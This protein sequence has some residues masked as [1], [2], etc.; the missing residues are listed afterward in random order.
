MSATPRELRTAMGPSTVAL[1]PAAPRLDPAEIEAFHA[2]NPVAGGSRRVP[3]RLAIL[4][5]I[6]IIL[7]LW[8][9]AISG[10]QIVRPV[11]M[12]P[13]SAIATSFVELVTRSSFSEHL[14][15]SLT[16][17]V[18]GVFLACIVGVVVGLGVGW[19]RFLELTVAPIIWTLYSIPKVAFAPLV[20][21][22]LGL[23]APSKVF[24]VFLLG[25]FPIAL[26]T[27]EGVRTVDPSLIRAARVYGTGGVPLARRVIL[28][29][30]LPYVLV[31]IRRAVAL[32][33]IGAM[34]GEFLGGNVGIGHLLKR[35]AH[36]FR[37][38]DALAIVVVMII[39]AN[40]GLVITTV[41]QRRIAPWS[42]R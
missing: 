42:I 15:F 6:V 35:A 26:N 30:I 23:G 17:L 19:S 5:E 14:W 2:R 12:P 41:V 11:F 7:G 3:W 22:A 1:A 29:A 4:A 10:L 28:P 33:F 25:V 40:L 16:N 37:M 24:L 34:L 8:E 27:I 31:G 20:I 32:G 18:V 13:P 39:V 21:L 9:F 36:D 38:D